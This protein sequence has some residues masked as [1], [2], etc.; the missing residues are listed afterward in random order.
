MQKGMVDSGP[1][2]AQM[3]EPSGGECSNR[4]NSRIVDNKIGREKMHG[5]WR[6]R[7]YMLG[8][9]GV[10]NQPRPA[11]AGAP[12]TGHDTIYDKKSTVGVERKVRGP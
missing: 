8:N 4:K 2:L 10:R 1:K 3:N 9:I 12:T 7:L 11:T 6:D 5:Q